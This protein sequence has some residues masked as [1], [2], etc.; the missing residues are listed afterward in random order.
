MSPLAPASSI[1]KS[2]QVCHTYPFQFRAVTSSESLPHCDDVANVSFPF[3]HT[4]V[5]SLTMSPLCSAQVYSMPYSKHPGQGLLHFTAT[6]VVHQITNHDSYV[7]DSGDIA[8]CKSREPIYN[9]TEVASISSEPARDMQ[10]G[11]SISQYPSH[12]S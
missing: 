6:P 1:R 3:Y 4:A 12:E 5:K 2:D 10:V 11:R 9:V 8:I 7:D